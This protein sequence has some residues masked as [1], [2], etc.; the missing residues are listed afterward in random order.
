MM[1]SPFSG[2]WLI[3]TVA[4]LLTLNGFCPRAR[5]AD[6]SPA[7]APTA[8]R[9]AHWAQRAV[10]GVADD[11]LVPS[12]R[13][14]A[15]LLEA[16]GRLDPGEPRYPRL[17]LD[18][19]LFL[20]ARVRDDSL[21]A[22]ALAAA[23]AYRSLAPGDR[24]VQVKVI[25]L[26]LDTM[27]TLDA[28][29]RYLRDLLANPDLHP[30]VRSAAAVR[31]AMLL[32]ERSM[33]E[34]L[35]ALREAQKLNPFNV[36][37]IAAEFAQT[38]KTAT[39]ERRADLC[40]TMLRANPAHSDALLTLA[41]ECASAGLTDESL[42]WID[43][44]AVASS[45]PG[46]PPSADL[47]LNYALQLFIAGQSGSSRIA[48]DLIG[49]NPEAYEA[50]L[51][52]IMQERRVAGSKLIDRLRMQ[53]RNVAVQ[54]L[55]R[56]RL[57]FDKAATTQV[58]TTQQ[59]QA[60]SLPV[61]DLSRDAS[62]L[63][64]AA[65]EIREQYFR[66]LAEL[67]WF[68]LYFNNRA[69]E[70]ERLTRVLSSGVAETNPSLVRLTGWLFLTAGRK[71]EAKVKLSATADK[72]PLAALGLVKIY[73]GVDNTACEAA[74]RQASAKPLGLT[75]AIVSDALQ[76]LG[77]KMV[78]LPQAA[79]IRKQ[80][81]AFPKALMRVLDN[82]KEFYILK[83]EALK[84]VH[85][86]Y[87]PIYV[88]LTITNTSN[89]EL[90][91]GRDGL[92]RPEVWVDVA[93]PQPLVGV[94]V[95]Q[96]AQQG[97]L[98]PRESVSQVIRV[99]H[100]MLA[101][102]LEQNPVPVF[103]VDLQFRLNPWPFVVGE[104][105]AV[106]SGAGGYSVGLSKPIERSGFPVQGDSFARLVNS[107][108]RA[109]APERLRAMDAARTFWV[110]LTRPPTDEQLKAEQDALVRATEEQRKAYQQQKA[111]QEQFTRSTADNLLAALRQTADDTDPLI[112]A[113]G[114]WTVAMIAPDEAQRAKALA[115]L[116][117]DAHWGARCLGVYGLSS[118]S[119]DTLKALA[120]PLSQADPD[121]TVQKLAG[122][123]VEIAN[124]PPPTQPS[125]APAT[126]P[127]SR[128]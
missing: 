100:G 86:L 61:P 55:T 88:R 24:D 3:V 121:R 82:P 7:D 23:N 47:W 112:R 35:A 49:A 60:T 53:A 51:L 98:R 74:L 13:L 8:A 12:S 58:A 63:A 14:A 11:R 44:L 52:R 20:R 69:D 102:L 59:V 115:G 105:R 126:R 79:P 29:L 65:D 19:L 62:A 107:I 73:A 67:A 42:F 71:D 106:A 94:A 116:V 15:A 123:L 125:T 97:V 54:Q 76:D 33:E 39:P 5:G 6:K 2:R 25:A 36:E 95:A 26:H 48:D 84:P 89:Y 40:L 45:R 91:L 34:S 57:V 80:I 93:S 50:L 77:R 10:Q 104:Q 90:T 110:L 78:P 108:A 128:P 43:R 68:E 85:L 127:A 81:D 4:C 118:L 16:A 1:N 17:A 83:A 46:Q 70:A 22:A 117:G 92:I 113:W 101:A 28:K 30:D 75:G 111:A 124:L 21:T 99:D 41:V 31:G 32:R 64:G 122:S 114:R 56:A 120:G 9:L 27:Q 119:T 38:A 72:D 18:S 87:E 66:A 109:D 37:A 103:T 96:L